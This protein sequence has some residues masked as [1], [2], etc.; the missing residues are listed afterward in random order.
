[1][2]FAPA[3]PCKGK[4]SHRLQLQYFTSMD[5]CLAVLQHGQTRPVDDRLMHQLPL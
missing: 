3:G 2:D 1:M 5:V 4:A